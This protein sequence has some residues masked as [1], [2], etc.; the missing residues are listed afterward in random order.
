MAGHMRG[1]L[2][3]LGVIAVCCAGCGKGDADRLAR[4]WRK[5]AS[6]VRDETGPAR[7]KLSRGWHALS[8][9]ADPSDLGSLVATRLRHDKGLAG[10][11]IEVRADGDVV[12]LKGHV[13][14]ADQR[15]RAVEVT[16]NTVGVRDVV[17]GLGE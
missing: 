16:R 10:A 17:D 15:R 3:G 2:G 9:E 1:W 6:Q 4:V 7:G 5:A 11:V 14:S 13:E 12:E 8:G